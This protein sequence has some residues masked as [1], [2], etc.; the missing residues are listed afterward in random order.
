MAKSPHFSKMGLVIGLA[1]ITMQLTASEK[2]T[3]I[4]WQIGKTDRN[5]A[6]FALAPSDHRKFSQDGF[7]IV[8]ASDAS[9][10]W[11]Y[12]QP[13]PGDAWAG[14]RPHTYTVAFGMKEG[15]KGDSCNLVIDLADTQ[16]SIPPKLEIKINNQVF[17]LDMPAGGGDQSINGEPSAG[18]PY[19]IKVAF[20]STLLKKGVN[21][22]SIT[23]K[24]GSWIL[25]DALRLEGPSS[26]KTEPMSSYLAITN[27]L[28]SQGVYSE[29][30]QLY[31]DVTLTVQ[32]AG[33]SFLGQLTSN[34][35]ALMPVS[36]VPGSQIIKVKRPE[37][38][39]AG[40][41]Q[42]TIQKGD[43]KLAVKDLLINPV[44]KMTVYILPHSHT[45]IGY[46]EIQTA[47]E[48]K[49]VQ[50]LVDGIRY[51]K[52]TAGYPEGARFIWNVE[53]TWAADLYLNRLG[54]QAK[55]DFFEAARNGQISFNGMYLNE[56]TGL[57]RPEELLHLF[58]YT[59]Q[60][61]K[62]TGQKIDAAMISD[63]PGYTW[64]TVTAMA[65]AG[66]RYFSVA[67]NYFD[68]I[69][70]IL[71]KWENKP[72]WW[73]S[74]SGQE[75]V[76]VWIPLKG[77]ALSH[78]I[79]KL[80]PEWVTDYLGQL[81]KMNYPYDIAHIRW[82]GHGDN[83]VPDPAICEFVKDWNTKYTW[84][85]FIISST[86]EAFG[87]F[88]K[89]YGNQIP[90]VAGDWTPYW[91]DG[92]G[93]SAL[94]TGLNR[95]TA[96]KLSQAE[97]LWALQNPEN[98]PAK[99]FEEAWNKVLL[100]SE[101]TWGAWCSITDPEN[102]MTKEQWE[103]KKSY[104]DDAALMTDELCK[105]LSV[106]VI[107]HKLDI[108]NTTG[109]KRNEMVFLSKEQS[110]IGEKVVD[111]TGKPLKT[112]RLSNGELAVL[113]VTVAPFS[114]SRYSLMPGKAFPEG[115][116][117]VGQ[118]TILNNL[119][120][121]E[122]DPVRGDIISLI[123]NR[124]GKNLI[125]KTGGRAANQYIFLEGNDLSNLKG[126]GKVKITIKEKG[127]LVGCLEITSEAPGCNNLTRQLWLADNA[128]FLVIVNVVDKK[129]APMPEKI[130]EWFDAQNKNKESVN[131]G[132][133]FAVNQGIMR[134]DLPLGQMIPEKDQMP[135]ACKNWFT[136][137]RWADVSNDNEG[138]TWVT[139]DAPLVEVGEISATLIGSQNNPDIWRK[140][141]QP[142]QTFYS[143]AMNN[144][145][146]TNYRQHQEGPVVFRYIL[147][148]H[149]AFD[150]TEASRFATGF[151]Q[152]LVIRPAG[153]DVYS[154]PFTLD[155]KAVTVIAFKPADDGEGFILTLYNPGKTPDK[156]T[157]KPNSGGKIYHCDTGETILGEL[158]PTVEL[159]GQ[160][161]MQVRFW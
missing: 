18:K 8:G 55:K 79:S 44:R 37:V 160:G 95:N 71:V 86:S 140:K 20:A 35:T 63:V 64:G 67:P 133:P 94:E 17:S 115:S 29:G 89:K 43:Q 107:P 61:A 136:V 146:G 50:N 24:S 34:G 148:P 77:Y 30:G 99:K 12:V 138:I 78:M 73:V 80:T 6:E 103:I 85:K 121:C 113:G 87:A 19:Q 102:Q 49:Q 161:V 84:P 143:W 47:I 51:A 38:T 65:Q 98:F 76:L 58:K 145:W 142:T 156:F 33:K 131:F 25:Y 2:K 4:V 69:G 42:F 53:V 139:L 48:A 104:A 7:Y 41:F 118:N 157:L 9:K 36:I 127:P 155:A 154:V 32:Y 100:Y 137:G 28:A 158:P 13:G 144:H 45:D 153:K 109:W 57:C 92:A 82:S 106:D 70:D 72:F 122:I 74:P 150:A 75:K 125:D 93:S 129:R 130:G 101:H 108:V 11:P 97:V 14:G 123:D 149:A 22:I 59:T 27:I 147:R 128:D 151:S 83:A 120:Q 134:L 52:Q 68:R 3:K 124:T 62:T 88:E 105:S 96:E 119:I 110:S 26:L 56:L 10:D 152:P 135:S 46:T 126:N 16:N 54:E 132:F 141:V 15:G 159:T 111:E 81:G 112:Q 60:L 21:E 116:V 5:T 66:I 117:A 114:S 23:S 31:R 90:S 40:I 39:Q 91:E 1:L